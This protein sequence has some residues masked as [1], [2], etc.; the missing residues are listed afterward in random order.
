MTPDEVLERV[1]RQ[2]EALLVVIKTDGTGAATVKV[3]E[4]SIIES[5]ILRSLL[6]M[7]RFYA[8]QSNDVCASPRLAEKLSALNQLI[9]EYGKK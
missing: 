8:G 1:I 6:K 2:K 7:R 4:R 3:I 5:K 9:S